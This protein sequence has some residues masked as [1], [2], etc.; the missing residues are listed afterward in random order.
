MESVRA[1]REPE[2]KS[3]AEP[4]SHL[5]LMKVCQLLSGVKALRSSETEIVIEESLYQLSALKETI[6]LILS[7]KPVALV[8]I[9]EFQARSEI[10]I[11]QGSK[12]EIEQE[13]EEI[14]IQ[15]PVSVELFK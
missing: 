4:E 13:P 9:E 8:Q 15:A 10:E 14:A 2:L 12:E 1:S 11:E 3:Q 5:Y 7:I 6:G